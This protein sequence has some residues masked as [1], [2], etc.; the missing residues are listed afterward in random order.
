V[1]MIDRDGEHLAALV[2]DPSLTD[3]RELLDAVSAAAGIALENGQLQVELRARL[4]ELKESRGRVIYPSAGAHGS[5]GT[6]T[7]ARSSG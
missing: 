5:S 6:C 4:E 3:G 1:T 7:T 2:H